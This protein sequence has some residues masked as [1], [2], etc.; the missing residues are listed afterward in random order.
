MI[1]SWLKDILQSAIF[2]IWDHVLMDHM[3][4]HVWI[5]TLSA[6]YIKTSGLHKFLNKLIKHIEYLE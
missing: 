5:R 1:S 2:Y 6:N 4:Q 3:T